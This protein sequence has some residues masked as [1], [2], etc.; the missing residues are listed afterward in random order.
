LVPLSILR[1]G[2]GLKPETQK[3]KSN[4]I[5]ARGFLKYTTML[6][7][8][9]VYH[10]TYLTPSLYLR[11]SIKSISTREFNEPHRRYTSNESTEISFTLTTPMKMEQIVPK[12]RHIT[13]RRRGMTHKKEYSKSL[14]S[15]S[16]CK[17]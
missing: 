6:Q 13:F 16:V 10:S 3:Q 17:I 12:R 1:S 4:Y 2:N 7:N 15:H 9:A 8:L 11:T 14:P 5:Y